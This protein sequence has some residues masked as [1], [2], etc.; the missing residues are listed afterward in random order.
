ML[1]NDNIPICNYAGAYIDVLGQKEYL[2]RF[3][4]LPDMSDDKIKNEFAHAVMKTVGTMTSI[5][6]LIN[7]FF[8]AAD[9][10]DSEMPVPE[11]L[12]DDVKRLT[13]RDV[14]FLK[15]SDGLFVYTTIAESLIPVPQFGVYALFLA[16]GML[17]LTCLAS[18]TAIRGGLEIGWGLEY[19][20]NQ[21]YG[22]VVSL[23]YLLESKIAQYPRFVI[24]QQM[25]EYL[26]M[27]TQI[28]DTDTASRLKKHSAEL[29]L[30]IVYEDNDGYFCIDFLDEKF[31]AKTTLMNDYEVL[32]KAYA[33]VLY[34][35]E[36]NKRKRNTELAFRYSI[37]RNYFEAKMPEW[38]ISQKD[39]EKY[40]G[41]FTEDE[42]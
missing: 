4:R 37:L 20:T 16:C 25:Q 11:L 26:H 21:L 31:L 32:K 28:K 42:I 8:A 41:V 22:S 27:S 3:T 5:T 38:G 9:K 10:V 24:G 12:K 29:C 14:K 15:F 19:E 35:S 36:I 33:Y 17:S 6:N 23:S 7:R 13:K 39:A 18:G 1:D 30:D 2:K 34:E 40:S